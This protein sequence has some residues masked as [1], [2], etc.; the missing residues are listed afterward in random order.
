MA[1]R[2]W[3]IFGLVNGFGL[4]LFTFGTIDGHPV[5]AACL[6]M[7]TFLLL[8]GTF[9]SS[10]I[11]HPIGRLIPNDT[12]ASLLVGLLAVATNAGVW[13]VIAALFHSRRQS[14]LSR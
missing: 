10:A 7:G 3:R 14:R 12:V 4:I 13:L 5:T 1:K 6:L 2:T 9:V 8:P 11:G